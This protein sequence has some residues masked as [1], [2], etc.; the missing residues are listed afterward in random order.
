NLAFTFGDGYSN[1]IIPTGVFTTAG[2]MG[3][4][5]E[6]WFKWISKLFILYFVL[7]LVMVSVATLIGL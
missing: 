5:V 6:K 3:L 7:E 4:P 1:M 2:L